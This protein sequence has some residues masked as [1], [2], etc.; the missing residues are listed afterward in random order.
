[1]KVLH[2]GQALIVGTEAFDLNDYP[3]LRVV[4]CPMTSIEHLPTSTFKGSNIPGVVNVYER[5]IKVISLASPRDKETEEFLSTVTSTAEHTIGLIIAL[6]RNYKTALNGPYKDRE[7][8]KGHT[9][10]GKTAGII[11]DGRIGK[12]VALALHHVGMDTFA[13]SKEGATETL[14]T[15]RWQLHLALRGDVITLHIPLSGNEGFFTKEMFKQMRPESY[16][17]N[18][19]RSG[20]VEKGA[21]LWA[22]ENGIIAGA[23]VDFIDDP[24]LVAYAQDHP[25]LILTNHLGGCTFEDQQKTEDF[26]IKKVTKYLNQNGYISG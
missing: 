3:D 18:T 4:G 13:C 17:V 1:M 25:N 16:F 10:S 26:I 6:L 14:P 22:L 7:E 19:S 20:V 5:A 11:G 21:L 9:L 24:E 8:Y 23:A 15:A 12:Q 2:N